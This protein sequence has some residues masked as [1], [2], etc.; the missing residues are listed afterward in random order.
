[1]SLPMSR[2]DKRERLPG[3]SETDWIYRDVCLD[4]LES[5]DN[6]AVSLGVWPRLLIANSPALSG[7]HG[8]FTLKKAP[9]SC[10][11]ARH[12]YGPGEPLLECRMP[13]PNGS[14][15]SWPKLKQRCA[16]IETALSLKHG[17]VSAACRSTR[18]WFNPSLPSY[19]CPGTTKTDQ[20][21]PHVWVCSS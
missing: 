13:G 8:S 12:S 19:G 15:T 5:T 6:P 4:A 3:H 7:T 20:V 16:D 18:G 9:S 14:Q 2:R 11:A 17:R 21:V 10:A 1:M